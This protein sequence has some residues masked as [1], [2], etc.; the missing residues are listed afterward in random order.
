M[1]RL[2]SSHAAASDLLG[3]VGSRQPGEERLAETAGHGGSREAVGGV[4][5]IS[6]PH[7]EDRR[8]G[9]RDRVG[10][11]PELQE[12]RR[13]V[14]VGRLSPFSGPLKPTMRRCAAAKGTWRYG[15]CQVPSN[16]VN[17]MSAAKAK[18]S[19][20]TSSRPYSR[21]ASAHSASVPA[22]Q[23][24]RVQRR[25]VPERVVAPEAAEER[26][27]E[28]R[29]ERRPGRASAGRASRLTI[30]A[31]APDEQ[32]EDDVERDQHGSGEEQRQP[33]ARRRARRRRAR[34]R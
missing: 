17:A 14:A 2:W 20:C 23:K 9:G 6:R 5:L 29:G 4:G 7:H 3:E 18:A 11:G 1:P 27:A 26:R 30:R 16:A 12:E 32:R 33:D 15:W 34:V 13:G 22:I 8:L 28:E 25:A 19:P 10:G 31:A 21:S 24:P